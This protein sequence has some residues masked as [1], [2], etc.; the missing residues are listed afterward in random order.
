MK[1]IL[2]DIETFSTYDLPS[3]GVY[4]YVESPEFD[5]L[6]LSYSID[7]GPVQ[8]VDLAMGESIPVEIV[9]AIKG[10]EVKKF[11]YNAQFERVCLSKYLGLYLSPDSW[12]C[13]MVHSSTLGLPLSLDNVGMILEIEN[14]KL[15]EGKQLIKFF[16]V[17]CEPKESNG[18][19]HRNMPEDYPEK[20]QQMK[21][22]NK[23][24]VEA[25]LEVH[26][27][28]AKFPVT[29]SEWDAYHLDQRIN[30]YG[31]MLDMEL[32]EHAVSCDAKNAAANNEKA[33][34]ITGVDNPNS[35]S[36]L[37]AWL[38]EQGMQVESLSK[39][40]VTRLL[41]DATG[42]VEEI[43]NL[44]QEMA[45]SSIKKYNAMQ[46]VCCAD[47]R[48][49]GLIQFAGASRTGRF[50]GRYVQV[51]NLPRNYIADLDG[52]RAL[53]KSED[54]QKIESEFGSITN[55]LSEL[56]RTAFIAKPGCRFIVSDFSAIE[57]RVLAW[58]A[59]EQWRQE[60]FAKNED[61]YCASA[62]QMF[63]VPVAK[64][65]PNAELR[66]KGKIAELALGYGGSVGALKAMGA[67][68]MGLVESELPEIVNAWRAAN[69]SITK[70]WWDVDRATKYVVKTHNPYTCYGLKFEYASGIMFITLPS[71]RKLAYCKP[72]I[73]ING[74]GSECVTYEG[75][76]TGKHWERIESYGPKFVE[77]ITQAIA[78]DILV[79]AMKRLDK[80]GY[81][82]TMHVHDEVVLE[83][84]DGTAS[85]DDV[86]KIMCETPVWA[87]GLILN[88]AGFECPFY[89]KD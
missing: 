28:L 15:K 18:Y 36:Q 31:I 74:F 11:S 20:W 87:E 83:V 50:A 39:A 76:G 13:D 34:V 69:P 45:K 26:N 60:A 22:Y 29:D 7:G 84:P 37:K 73:G 89:Q 63:G 66:P 49:R 35:P 38:V 10:N 51:Q 75:V 17:P 12:F 23:R 44:R 55:T 79:E 68:N 9:K 21:A 32:V 30:D 40:E 24:D 6:V 58:L 4:K 42:N 82:I 64:N 27:R 80:A 65:G 19:K 81:K 41:R 33:K 72:R 48:A 25:E 8:T 53:V 56:I 70:F 1:E 59:K 71:E 46:N 52:A 57:A 85:I 14:A 77:N 5:I 62:S 3:C 61:I 16:C 86:N 43:L 67:C 47:K 54:L 2:I 78:R 88:A